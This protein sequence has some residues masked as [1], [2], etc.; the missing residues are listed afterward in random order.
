MGLPHIFDR[1]WSGHAEQLAK[2][3]QAAGPPE[4]K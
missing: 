4:T 3:R 1:H 2:I